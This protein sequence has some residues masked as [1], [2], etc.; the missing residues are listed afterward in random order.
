LKRLLIPILLFLFPLLGRAQLN[1]DGVIT[2]GRNALYYED[3]A[4]S[5]QYFNQV[6]QAK[7]YLYEPYYYRA[8]A[9]YYLGDYI[10]AIDDCSLSIE[11][12]PFIDD[13]FRLRAISYIMNAE[14][15]KA[16]DDYRLLLSR[17]D[18]DKDIWHNLV[19]C[20]TSMDSLA[21]A[22]A[23]L[24]TMIQKWPTNARCYMLK[25]QI[26]LE[27]QDTVL[28]DTLI[29]QTLRINPYD[30]DALGARAMLQMQ[31]EEY[32]NAEE[33]YDRAILQSPKKAGFYLNR[34]MA[35]FRRNNLRGAMDDYNIALDIDP[36]NYPGHYNRGLLRMQVG[37]NNLA[38]EDF[39][40]VLKREPR[41]RLALFNRA[42]LLEQTGD[43]RG[44]IRD[45]TT[46]LEDYPNFLTGY[47][48]R[49]RCR[50]LIGQDK[51]ALA[52]ERKVYIARLDDMF[53]T[54]HRRRQKPT[55]K[56]KEQ[57]IDDYKKMVVEND[58]ENIAKFYASDYR[59]RIQN[60]DVA[61][62][63]QPL[64]LLTF[65]PQGSGLAVRSSY[66]AFL[67]K[68]NGTGLLERQVY[69]ASREG[70][71]DAEDIKAIDADVLRLAGRLG[72]ES[73]NIPLLFAHAFCAASKRDYTAALADLDQALSLDSTYVAALFLRAVVNEKQLEALQF[74]KGQ[75]EVSRV[76]DTRLDYKPVLD[77]F[78]RAIAYEPSCGYIY[79][80]RGCIHA[81]IKDI[82]AALQDYDKAIEC[83]PSLAEAYYNRGL[84]RVELADYQEGFT[85]LSKAGEL[86][87]YSAYSLIKHFRKVQQGIK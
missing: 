42:L 28:A 72:K 9:K 14:Y 76:Q 39:N 45:Y 10:G 62:E 85:D 78:S 60:R 2:I 34:A 12:D 58:E 63:S 18:D 83:Q 48:N 30:V 54:G 79:Y 70:A 69:L 40:F 80:N 74:K 29:S 37:E 6:I 87:L 52:D 33:T 64:Y 8:V 84:L 59:G 11:R 16:S 36:D 68:F 46:V 65:L 86:G 41:D 31:R 19:L 55:R 23:L 81:R 4:L 38:I 61:V 71:L 66:A 35:R 20:Q 27:R 13:V 77:D 17:R 22:D 57:D 50:R 26:A 44:A 73:R 5:I 3:Y 24:D 47:E 49:A 15:T 75:G 25:A 51:L 82:A 7:P 21:T 1:A 53:G 32:A 43:Y 67:D 56:Q